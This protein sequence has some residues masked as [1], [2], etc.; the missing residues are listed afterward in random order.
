MC[1]TRRLPQVQPVYS[2]SCHWET[3]SDQARARPGSP[4]SRLFVPITMAT[5]CK[6]RSGCSSRSQTTFPA[7]GSHMNS[8]VHVPPSSPSACALVHR[9]TD[10][11]PSLNA[12]EPLP[13]AAGPLAA[14][15][16]LPYSHR[17]R[18]SPARAPG[19]AG[20]SME[21]PCLASQGSQESLKHLFQGLEGQVLP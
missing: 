15:H 19:R 10:F 21:K 5:L 12:M 16:A 1:T 9:K 8:A 4:V 13:Q 7:A 11:L 17:L 20:S 14:W 18:H 2:S 6:Q 3:C